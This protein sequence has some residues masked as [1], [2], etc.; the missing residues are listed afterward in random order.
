MKKIA[1]IVIAVLCAL[2]VSGCGVVPIA[3]GAS[4]LS[5]RSKKAKKVTVYV[6]GQRHDVKTVPEKK[7]DNVKQTTKNTIEIPEGNHE[8]TVKKDDQQIHKETVKTSGEGHNVVE[9]KEEPK[10]EKKR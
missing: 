6:D 9:L 5:V 3:D 1:A 10:D 7:A 4:T 2:M 8:V